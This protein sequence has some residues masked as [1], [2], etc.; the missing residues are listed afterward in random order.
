[1]LYFINYILN[2][3]EHDCCL[4]FLAQLGERQTEDLKVAGSIPAEG[5]VFCDGPCIRR[6][7]SLTKYEGNYQMSSQFSGR[8]TDCGSVNPGPIPGELSFQEE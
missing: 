4:A 2:Y 6:T 8:T 1:M 7:C 5:I 3:F